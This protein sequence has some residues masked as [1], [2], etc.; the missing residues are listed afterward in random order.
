MIDYEALLQ[1]Q[2]VKDLLARQIPATSLMTG[3]Q[4]LSLFG[5][6]VSTSGVLAADLY[7][8]MGINTSKMRS[9]HLS[10]PCGKVLVAVLCHLAQANLQIQTV[11]QARDACILICTI[12]S[13]MLSFK[14]EL[15]VTVT[16]KGTGTQLEAATKIPGQKYDWG[17]GKKIL[18][19]LFES[20]AKDI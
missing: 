9:Q 12:P 11:Q 2:G 19:R 17:K 15:I 7:S 18:E 3:E 5:K 6:V 16:K 4:F 14:G 13:D 8:R 20:A 10:R 1:V